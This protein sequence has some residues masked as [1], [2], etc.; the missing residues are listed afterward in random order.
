MIRAARMEMIRASRFYDSRSSGL[1][2][3]FLDEVRNG[4]V[5][6]LQYPL[7]HTLF[8]PPYRRLLIQRFPYGVVYRVYAALITVVAVSNRLLR[9]NYWR[10]R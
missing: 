6:L 2:N 10:G 1:G 3:D 5:Q 9:P 4:L 8:D 7:A